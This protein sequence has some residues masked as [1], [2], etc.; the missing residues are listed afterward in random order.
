VWTALTDPDLWPEWNP[1]ID[2]IEGTIAAGETIGIYT[3]E[4]PE[5]PV[6]VKV[7]EFVPEKRMVW[8]GGMRWGVYV[9]VRT[10]LLDAR[11]DGSTEFTMRVV[12]KGLLAFFYDRSI[13]DMQPTFDQFAADLKRHCEVAA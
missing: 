7:T 6:T 12:Y 2:R 13:P 11:D 9:G 4:H 3:K 1:A 5:Y 10:Y 8:S